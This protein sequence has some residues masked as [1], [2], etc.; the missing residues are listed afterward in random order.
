ML[1]IRDLLEAMVEWHREEYVDPAV[2]EKLIRNKVNPALMPAPSVLQLLPPPPG[3]P[4]SSSLQHLP[5][6]PK[7]ARQPL[8]IQYEVNDFLQIILNEMHVFKNHETPVV[9]SPL[10]IY[11]LIKISGSESFTRWLV[12]G[13]IYVAL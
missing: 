12:N 2:W 10:K 6:P 8:E 4:G 11:R 1:S 5:Y 13:K 3:G 9:Q 7:R